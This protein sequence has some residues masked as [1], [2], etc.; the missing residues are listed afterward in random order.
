MMYDANASQQRSATVF[1][2]LIKI[3]GFS[4]YNAVYSTGIAQRVTA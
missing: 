1:R 2:R 3:A 4:T